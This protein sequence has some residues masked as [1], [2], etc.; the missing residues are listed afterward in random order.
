[1]CA[2]QRA[3]AA[4][5]ISYLPAPCARPARRMDGSNRLDQARAQHQIWR[6]FFLPHSLGKMGGGPGSGR[7]SFAFRIKQMHAR[8]VGVLSSKISCPL[9]DACMDQVWDGNGIHHMIIIMHA[10]ASPT[11]S[12]S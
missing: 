2:V 1:V 5:W 12:P 4:G 7:D 6:E 3:Q 9:G 11:W 8:F 10:N